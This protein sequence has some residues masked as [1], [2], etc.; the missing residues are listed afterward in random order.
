MRAPAPAPMRASG[1]A[2]ICA[3]ASLSASAAASLSA[4]AVA[5]ICAAASLCDSAAAAPLSASAA[6]ASFSA[7]APA[8]LCAAAPVRAANPDA[9]DIATVH[10]SRTAGRKK[11]VRTPDTSACV[12]CASP[13]RMI[14]GTVPPVCTYVKCTTGQDVNDRNG[15][16]VRH[17]PCLLFSTHKYDVFAK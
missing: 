2:P 9:A 3:A 10:V 4:S 12:D 7:S 17:T 14:Q 11:N 6:A 13:L 8:P 15:C 16:T 5:P 1:P